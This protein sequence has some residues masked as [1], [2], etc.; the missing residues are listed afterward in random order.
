MPNRFDLTASS[1]A[2][3]L[4]RRWEPDPEFKTRPPMGGG[5]TGAGELGLSTAG[6]GAV[7]GGK[8]SPQRG[9]WGV[10]GVAGGV[11]GSRPGVVTL[12]HPASG[13]GGCP[14][15]ERWCVIGGR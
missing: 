2:I 1:G 11:L 7:S 10:G 12:A 4:S 15:P 8:R 3:R 5:G 14:M 13:S 6:R 9:R